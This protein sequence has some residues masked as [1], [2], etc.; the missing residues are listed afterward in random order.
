MNISVQ[1]M[2]NCTPGGM[3][4]GVPAELKFRGG[5]EEKKRKKMSKERPSSQQLRQGV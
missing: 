1:G 5:T 3:L 2:L 4:N